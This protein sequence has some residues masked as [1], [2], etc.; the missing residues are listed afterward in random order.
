MI[1]IPI[2][3]LCVIHESSIESFV[4]KFY[5]VSVFNNDF[6]VPNFFLYWLIYE[7]AKFTSLTKMTSMV[8]LVPTN[9]MR[10]VTIS[11]SFF[12]G[13]CIYFGSVLLLIWLIAECWYVEKVIE[14]EFEKAW[15]EFVPFWMVKYQSINC[16][17]YELNWLGYRHTLPMI[18]NCNL[19]FEF[20]CFFWL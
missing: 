19:G 9:T 20:C 17:V 11:L 18:W 15:A 7:R 13:F 3:Y 8:V 16:L 6:V 5:M 10:V 4:D 2:H 14:S 1:R 12:F